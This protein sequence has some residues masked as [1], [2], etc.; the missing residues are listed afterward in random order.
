MKTEEATLARL[1]AMAQRGDRQAYRVLLGECQSWLKG[2]FRRR[3]APH[4]LDDLVQETLLSLHRK[5]GSYDPARP[6]L[7]WLAAISRYRWVDHM[8]RLYRDDGEAIEGDVPADPE[9]PAIAARLSLERLFTYLPQAQARVIELVKVEGL[10]IREASRASGQSE[11]LVKVNIHRGLK[12]LAA[13]I[14]KE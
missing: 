1:A 12:K 3:I 9:E 6:F 14:E 4:H 8:R 10:S 7:P 2:Y 5:L 11:S 13:M